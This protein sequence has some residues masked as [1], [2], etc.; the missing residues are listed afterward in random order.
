MFI[1]AVKCSSNA[2]CDTLLKNHAEALSGEAVATPSNVLV[3]YTEPRKSDVISN[4]ISGRLMLIDGTSIMYRSYYKLLGMI[5]FAL[6]LSP[7]F[8]C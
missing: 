7:F 2:C 8:R 6:S 1:G 5:F 4:T 3:N